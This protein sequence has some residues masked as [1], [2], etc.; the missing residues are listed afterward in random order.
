MTLIQ[1]KKL[2]NFPIVIFN[3]AYHQN[4]IELIED[5]KKAGTISPEDLDLLII[6]DDMD[7]AV[8][9]IKSA[10]SKF[11]LKAEKKFTPLKWLSEENAV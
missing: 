8:Q 10:I 4:L 6:T 3:R 1:T 5:M 7:E 2:K 9:H 11:D